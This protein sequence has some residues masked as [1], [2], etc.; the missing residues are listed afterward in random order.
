MLNFYFSISCKQCLLSWQ[1]SLI[2]LWQNFLAMGF[3]KYSKKA[4]YQDVEILPAACKSLTESFM[5]GV[6]LMSSSLSLCILH[7]G[8]PLDRF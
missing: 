4:V 2:E 5:T 1:Y 7:S 3:N 6:D 8:Y